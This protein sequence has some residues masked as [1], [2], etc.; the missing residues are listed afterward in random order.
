MVTADASDSTLEP[1]ILRVN[2]TMTFVFHNTTLQ[3]TAHV[4]G[5]STGTSQLL[6]YFDFTLVDPEL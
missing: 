5:I 2:D 3:F 6:F 1:I 4:R